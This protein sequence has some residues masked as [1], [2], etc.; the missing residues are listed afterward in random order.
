MADNTMHTLNTRIKLKYDSYENWLTNDPVLLSGELAIATIESTESNLAG[1]KFQNLPN[2]VIKVGNGTAKYS[3]LKFVSG[4]A[5]DVYDWAK[6]SVNDFHDDVREW[7]HGDTA[8]VEWLKGFI[9]DEIEDTDTR[10]TIMT[11]ETAPYVIKLMATDPQKSDLTYDTLVASIDL[12]TLDDRLKTVE[13]ALGEGGSVSK[14]ISDAVAAIALAKQTAG[15]GKVFDTIEQINGIV[16]VTTRDLG[17]ADVS[18]L[19]EALDAC[20]EDLPIDGTPSEDN[21]V[22]TQETVTNA[23]NALNNNDAAVAKEFVTAVKETNG[24]VEV[25]RRA[26]EAADI[27]VIEQAQV[28][29]LGDALKAKQD[30]L[31]IADEYNAESNPV[32][33][34]ATVT[35]AVANLEGAMHFRGKVEG[36]TLDAAIAASDITDWAAGDVVLWGDYE[37][38]FDGNAW[39]ELG[40][41]NLYQLKADAEAEHNALQDAIDELGEGKQDNIV[42]DETYDAETNKAATVKSITDRITTNNESLAYA[43]GD[44]AEH[45]FV[46]KV[47]QEAGVVKAEYAQPAVA[48]IAG[49]DAE[50]AR[51]DKAIEDMDAAKQDN[52]PIDGTASEE[53]KVATISSVNNAI[54]ALNK[55]DAAVTGQF[56]TAVAE[57][58]GII[59]VTRGDVTTDMIKQGELVLVFDCGTSQI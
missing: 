12:S 4:L 37:Y 16:T 36:D 21:K 32:A 54:N 30:V 47:T 44:A 13:A 46:S 45:K 15:A 41:T 42:F 52:L 2:V 9:A 55:A 49:L 40:N 6:R 51:I 19:Q 34:V 18:G 8:H 11:E 35:K 53:N 14:Q 5:A 25:S 17:I 33:T 26:L 50:I 24:V 7:M 48:D 39:I 20:Q 57:E 56:V 29:G 23:I 43:G 3:E 27:P 59:S 1:T 31:T 38:V 28:N 22:A 58:N 10:Y